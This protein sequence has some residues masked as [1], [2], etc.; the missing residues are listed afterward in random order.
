VVFDLDTR[1]V[2]GLHMNNLHL[3]RALRVKCRS[4]S[5]RHNRSI[6]RTDST[7]LGFNS[8]GYD[9]LREL[10][11]ISGFTGSVLDLGGYLSRS[12]VTL[13]I[14]GSPETSLKDVKIN[15]TKLWHL[16]LS[17]RRTKPFQIVR[18]SPGDVISVSWHTLQRTAF[19]FLS[20]I[21]QNMDDEALASEPE[22]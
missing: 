2:H 5:W 15:F 4:T 14:A 18:K 22:I 12:E 6:L 10:S 7:V 8:R 17:V 16:L 3:C 21:V 1:K 13:E 20:N 11:T 19:I 9:G